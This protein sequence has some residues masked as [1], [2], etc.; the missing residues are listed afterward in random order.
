MDRLSAASHRE[1]SQATRRPR[2]PVAP[3][4]SALPA[5]A[6]APRPAFATARYDLPVPAGP[7]PITMSFSAI[8]AAGIPAAPASWG[9]WRAAIRES[10]IFLLS[11][12]RSQLGD[13]PLGRDPEDILGCDR[14]TGARQIDH[15]LQHRCGARQ[16]SGGA[17]H[18]DGIAAL[19]HANTERPLQLGEIGLVDPRERE[20]ICAG[21]RDGYAGVLV[22]HEFPPVEIRCKAARSPA[23]TGV[24]APSKSARAAAV[25]GKAMTSRSDVAQ[26]SSMAIRSKPSAKP[27]CGGAPPTP[28]RR[29]ET[30]IACAARPA[31]CRESET[32]SP[33][34]QDS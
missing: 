3:G 11:A 28:A 4:Q 23:S 14:L 16:L 34:V 9:E 29:A 1:E 19:R 27:P 21:G 17:D 2:P 24:G 30:R 33:E 32:R 18:G 8:E 22:A 13:V 10:R 12:W 26:A 20:R 25:F 5:F 15:P 6:R 7:M 31:P